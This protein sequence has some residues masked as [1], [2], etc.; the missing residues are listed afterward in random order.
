MNITLIVVPG[1]CARIVNISTNTTVE[2][3]IQQENLHG[4]DIIINGTSVLPNA[5]QT[6]T[7]PQDS[8]VF[9]TGSVKGNAKGRPSNAPS[10]TGNKS[11]GSRGN[12]TPSK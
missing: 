7:I 9:A 10:T 3:L 2:A 12:N 6:T 5:Y 11:G 1:T 8:E 4:R